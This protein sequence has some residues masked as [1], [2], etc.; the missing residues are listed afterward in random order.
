MPRVNLSK[1][2]QYDLCVSAR[3]KLGSS[4]VDLARYLSVHPHTFDNWYKGERL[5][6]ENIFTKLVDISGFKIQNPQL[7][8]DNWGQAKG[9]KRSIELHGRFFGT[10]VGRR[11]GAQKAGINKAGE[12]PLPNYSDKLAEFIGIM[13]GDGGISSNQISV[14]L[15]YTTDKKYVPFI[16]KLIRKLFSAR[17]STYRSKIKDAIR[18]RASGVNLVNN[19]LILGRYYFLLC[20]K[21]TAVFSYKAF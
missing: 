10:L 5:L 2:D 12:F 9:G 1:K 13:L 6:P 11:K 18:I 7:L 21:T 20:I 8:P 17:T 15:G 16:R 4:W 19:L 14:T 3:E